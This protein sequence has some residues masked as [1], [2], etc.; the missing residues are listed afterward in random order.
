MR[1]IDYEYIANQ[2]SS[3]TRIPIRVYRDNELIHYCNPTHFPKD[4]AAPFLDRFLDIKQSVSYYLTPYE[5]FYGIIFHSNL[6]FVIGPTYQI[7]PSREKIREFMFLLDLKA[8]YLELYQNLMHDI[9]PMPLELFLRELCLIY[10]FIS[11]EK[12]N[13]SDI[14][15]YDSVSAIASQNENFSK[16]PAFSSNLPAPASGDDFFSD[17][18]TTYEFESQ[19]LHF[20][21]NGDMDGLLEHVTSHSTGRPGKVAKTYLRQMKNIF[22]SSATLVSR[23]AIRGGLPTE[24]ALSLSDRYIQHCENHTDPEQIMNLQYHMVLDYTSLVAELQNGVRYDKFLRSVTS[25]VREHLTEHISVEQIAKDLYVSRSYLSTK[26]KKETGETLSS[27]IQKQ[28][29]E[30]AK[31]YLKNT[32]KSILEISTYLGF[33]SQGYFQNVFKKHTGMTPKEFRD[34]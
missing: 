5:Q 32:K 22:I 28:Q 13:I 26:F 1:K 25:Y 10:Y 8:N 30:R 24:E 23:A 15:I 21:E 3:L 29:I 20:V 14:A 34:A 6:R 7:A 11:E 16:E 27:Y 19:M 12:M 33:S 17:E 2:I 31:D 9:T 18:H 4:P